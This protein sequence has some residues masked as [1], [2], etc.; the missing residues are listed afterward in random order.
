MKFRTPLTGILFIILLVASFIVMGEPPDADEPVEEIAS[1]YADNKDEIVVGSLMAGPAIILLLFFANHLRHRFRRVAPDSELATMVLVGPIIL[2]AGA[3]FDAT[4]SLAM[5][6]AVEDVEPQAM[7]TMQA[8][9]DNDFIPMAAGIATF[10]L[11]IG[12]FVLRYGGLPKWLG[13]IA[14][15]LGILG[16]TPVGFFAFMGA[17]LW[18]LIVSLLLMRGDDSAPAAPPV[19]PPAV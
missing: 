6:E 19:A 17:G 9:W 10:M 2:G 3:L 13:W 7:Q 11:S 18:V 12:I 8:I 1:H 4:L 16:F 5:A 14:L 15:V